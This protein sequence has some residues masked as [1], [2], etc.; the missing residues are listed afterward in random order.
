MYSW[1]KNSKYRQIIISIF[2]ISLHNAATFLEVATINNLV[3]YFKVNS[4]L[5]HI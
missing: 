3:Y 4:K 5:S 1:Y 2:I